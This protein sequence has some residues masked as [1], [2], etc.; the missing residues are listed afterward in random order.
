MKRTVPIILALMFAVGVPATHAQ[1]VP[2]K[3]IPAIA[4]A[5][6][7][8]IVS[9]V[10]SDRDGRPIAQG[11]GFLV[12]KDG[13]IVTN[14]HVIA[15]GSSAVAKL[16]D[17]AFYIVD[18]VLAFDKVRDIAVIKAHGQNFRTLALG[19]S[20]RVQIGEEVVAIGNPLSLE[21]TVS[22]G[23]VSGIRAVKDEGG[24]YLQITAPISP[25]SS[26]G[27]LFNMVGEVVGITTMYLKGGENLNFAIPINAAK[28]LLLTNSSRL[29]NLPNE[30]E[31][32]PT[33]APPST[34]D[35]GLIAQTNSPA[36]QSYLE[37]LK[38]GDTAFRVSTY[39]CF[40]DDPQSKT[41]MV[42]NASLL[43]DKRTMTVITQKFTSGVSDVGGI[44]TGQ[45]TAFSGGNGLFGTL[46]TM[47]DNKGNPSHQTDIL[48]W[49]P[50]VLAMKTGFGKLLPGQVRLTYEFKMQRSTGRYTE[51]TVF[52]GAGSDGFTINNTGKCIR[53]PNTRTP[54]ETY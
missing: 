32:A 9:I 20:D 12:S 26:G 47:Y 2:R 51:Q 19:N 22:N 27:P 54:E 37:L 17:G 45:L 24:K 44:F 1:S 16:P 4:K 39:A 40:D 34:T 28:P 25:G 38:S 46:H 48:E 23:I 35:E 29:Q 8:A 53:I 33:D 14:Y 36:Y 31:S 3:D 52:A 13:L 11:S 6:N 50:D 21:S 5:A 41:F 7:G 30:N 42:M 10:L 18:G 43:D 15:E 49:A